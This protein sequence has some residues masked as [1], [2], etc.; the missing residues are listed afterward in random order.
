MSLF[1]KII[2]HFTQISQYSYHS[3]V[4]EFV[5]T[6]VSE[7]VHESCFSLF[8]KR[9][10]LEARIPFDVAPYCCQQMAKSSGGGT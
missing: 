7:F 5:H 8:S 10:F 6:N 4:P 9:P 1:E 2:Q 3:D